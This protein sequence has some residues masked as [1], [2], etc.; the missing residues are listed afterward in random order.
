M[1]EDFSI[2]GTSIGSDWPVY[3]VAEMSANHANDFDNA[4]KII[5]AAADSGADAIKL[6]TYKPETMTIDSDRELFRIQNESKWSGQTLFELYENASTPWDWQPEL[7]EIAEKNDL[8]FFSTAFDESSADF[9]DD[10]EVPVHKI[11]SFE[12]VDLPLIKR[13]ASSGKPLIISTGMGTL[14]EIEDAVETAREAGCEEIILL[15]CVSSYPA[16]PDTMNLKTINALSETFEVPVGLSDH[17]RGTNIPVAA[18]TL[19]ACMIEKHFTISRSIESPDSHFSLEPDEFSQMVESVREAT[20]SLGQVKFGDK[21][22]GDSELT[23]LR[24]SL[25]VVE[26]MEKGE[27]L[28]EDNVRSIRPGHGLAPK[29][30]RTVLGM[31]L[32]TDVARGTPL[33]WKHVKA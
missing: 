26:D 18:S 6:Q 11:G 21:E 30:Y 3:F 33:E 24:R 14:G 4:R 12:L 31:K 32:V 29:H 17:T 25:F 28:T 1:S 20:R 16:D 23:S 10:L 13:L 9:L 27:T 7:Q 22:S 19:G 5:E 2:D 15:H 8:D